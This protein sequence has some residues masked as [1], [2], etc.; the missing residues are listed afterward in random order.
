[1]TDSSVETVLLVT[2]GARGTDLGGCGGAETVGFSGSTRAVA[3]VHLTTSARE[4]RG[5]LAHLLLGGH[6]AHA[7]VT[8]HKNTKS[9]N[10]S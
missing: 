6:L 8:R 7:C 1:M 4:L 10:I 5:T 3:Q 9:V 2:D